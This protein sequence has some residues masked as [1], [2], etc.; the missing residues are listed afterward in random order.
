MT[1]PRAPQ[2]EPWALGT[3]I[4]R[5]VLW[6]GVGWRAH[7]HP[8]HPSSCLNIPAWCAAPPAQPEGP[9]LPGHIPMGCSGEDCPQEGES[10]PSCELSGRVK[11]ARLP[12]GCPWL[13]LQSPRRACEERRT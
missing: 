5:L 2:L 1:D 9:S 7:P 6:L 3:A 10:F 8:V 4:R 12:E 11:Q 13:H